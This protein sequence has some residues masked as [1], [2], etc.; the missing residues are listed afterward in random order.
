MNMM[1]KT[2]MIGIVRELG[3]APNR[4]GTPRICFS[5]SASTTTTPRLIARWL[6]PR[7]Y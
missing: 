5:P 4:I 6:M 3:K 2:M 7:K 1:P